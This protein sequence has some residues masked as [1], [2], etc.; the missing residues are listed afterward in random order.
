MLAA[1][2]RLTRELKSSK[3]TGSSELIAFINAKG[4][5]GGSFLAAN[6]AHLLVAVS[7]RKVALVDLDLQLGNLTQYL[8][9]EPKRGLIEAL[10]VA[11]DLDGVSI[12]AYLTKH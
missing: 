5:S 3:K 4:G 8:D 10:D 12:E 2:R 1:V 7:N 9:L 11:A 6:I